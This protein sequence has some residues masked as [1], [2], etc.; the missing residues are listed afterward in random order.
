MKLIKVTEKNG[1]IKYINPTYVIDV[2]VT[3]YEHSKSWCVTLNLDKKVRGES[4]YIITCLTQED[5]DK[6][7][8]MLQDA[9]GEYVTI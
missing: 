4:F 1:N 9:F 3:Y 7:L 6:T 5:L 8:G 2:D